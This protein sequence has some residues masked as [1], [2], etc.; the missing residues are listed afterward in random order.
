MNKQNSKNNNGQSAANVEVRRC[1]DYDSGQSPSDQCHSKSLNYEKDNNKNNERATIY[2]EYVQKN[3]IHSFDTDS[4]KQWGFSSPT[5]YVLKQSLDDGKAYDFSKE[6]VYEGCTFYKMYE[7]VRIR[8]YTTPCFEFEYAKVDAELHEVELSENRDADDELVELEE[9]QDAVD[10]DNKGMGFMSSSKTVF[11]IPPMP[12]EKCGSMEDL[13]NVVGKA[14]MQDCSTTETKAANRR[15]RRAAARKVKRNNKHQTQLGNVSNIDGRNR[16]ILRDTCGS[17]GYDPEGTLPAS[18]VKVPISAKHL[19]NMQKMFSRYRRYKVHSVKFIVT[20]GFPQMSG[21]NTRDGFVM[22]PTDDTQD[23]DDLMHKLSSCD[24]KGTARMVQS[25][26]RTVSRKELDKVQTDYLYT[27]DDTNPRM[28]E[29]GFFYVQIAAKPNNAGSVTVDVELDVEFAQTTVESGDKTKTGFI[30]SALFCLDGKK[31]VYLGGLLSDRQSWAETLA[32]W[33]TCPRES[34]IIEIGT[35]GSFLRVQGSGDIVPINFRHLLVTPEESDGQFFTPIFWGNSNAYFINDEEADFGSKDLKQ[36]PITVA[37]ISFK[38][39]ANTIDELNQSTGGNPRSM[40]TVERKVRLVNGEKKVSLES[41]RIEQPRH[42]PTND[43]QSALTDVSYQEEAFMPEELRESLG[44]EERYGPAPPSY[45]VVKIN[46]DQVEQIETQ[47]VEDVTDEVKKEHKI[48]RADVTSGNASTKLEIAGVEATVVSEHA[49]TR[50]SV[51]THTLPIAAEVT[52]VLGVVSSTEATVKTINNNTGQ[53]LSVVNN[54]LNRVVSINNDVTQ[55]FKTVGD[56]HAEIL[57]AIAK[58]PKINNY[59]LIKTQLQVAR[60]EY[61]NDADLFKHSLNIVFA[62][63][64]LD[65]LPDMSFDLIISLT[66]L[67]TWLFQGHLFA[68]Q[69]G[70]DLPGT[71]GGYDWPSFGTMTHD[72]IVGLYFRT[73]PSYSNTSGH[74]VPTYTYFRIVRADASG[75]VYCTIHVAGSPPLPRP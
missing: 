42:I 25:Y 3:I 5:V 74:D 38:V 26:T 46:S 17:F 60:N 44:I 18:F 4:L 57:D 52:S 31:G 66:N 6:F 49:V 29:Y 12:S 22:D 70:S 13:T 39:V 27:Q 56:E 10:S 75:K 20:S 1:Q 51:R 69:S 34:C 32:F 15:A 41:T 2:E 40:Q 59:E 36:E 45:P 65:P 67:R 19:P 37:D 55:G 35:L 11:N 68:Y 64:G 30:P 16:L 47:I 8:K 71:D 73:Q 43:A 50:T 7:L 24:K 28:S 9:I 21:G 23:Y 54:T 72:D 53:T 61:E 58:I 62:A 33:P 48:T 14:E 63:F